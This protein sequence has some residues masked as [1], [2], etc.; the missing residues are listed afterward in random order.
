MSTAF[1]N[2]S[3]AYREARDALARREAEFVRQ[4]EAVTAQRQ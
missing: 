1:P 2:E 3:Q 4:M